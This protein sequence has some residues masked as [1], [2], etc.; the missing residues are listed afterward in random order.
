[1]KIRIYLLALM[2]LFSG[3][4]LNAGAATRVASKEQAELR[5]V[6]INSRV[7]EI[8][9][10]DLSQ[11]TTAQ[12]ADLKNELRNSK[13]ELRQMAPYVYISAGALIL[14]IILILLLL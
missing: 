4:S 2:L 3:I 14:I 1:M 13:A 8:K 5:F 9:S 6:E 7:N 11:L 12:R 10:L